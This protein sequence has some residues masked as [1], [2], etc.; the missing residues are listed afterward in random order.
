VPS[1]FF[2]LTLEMLTKVALD[3]LMFAPAF[4]GI[5]YTAQGALE[6]KSMSEIIEKLKKVTF[7]SN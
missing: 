4:I 1:N 3:Q 5:F 2:N 6:G 7:H